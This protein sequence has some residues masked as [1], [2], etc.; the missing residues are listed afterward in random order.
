MSKLFIITLPHLGEGI[1]SA[2]VSEVL[3]SPGDEINKDDPII[4]LESE[5]ASMEI[6]TETGGT[7]KEVYVKQGALISTGDKIISITGNKGPQK[8][9]SKKT[10]QEVK[11][12]ITP[13]DIHQKEAYRPAP[14]QQTP[15]DNFRTSPSVRKLARELNINL[16]N[17]QGTGKK[18]RIT[19]DD[20]I[21]KIKKSMSGAPRHTQ[22][23]TDFSQWG[24]VEYSPLS[25]IKKIT[26]QR[27]ESAWRSIPQVTQFDKADIT[28]LDEHRQKINE[29]IETNKTTFLPFLIKASV[30]TLKEFPNFNSSLSAEK[31]SLIHKNYYH[32]SIAVNTPG[33]LVV[34]VVRDADKK[35]IKSLSEELSDISKRARQK[36]LKPEEFKGGTFTLSS[37]GGIGG[38]YF[39]PIINPPQVAILGVSRA[40]WESVFLRFD[41][42]FN[43][44]Y[45]L[46]L[47]LTYDHRVID[48]VEAATFTQHLGKILSNLSC[49]N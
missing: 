35:D 47:S 21:N 26:G 44:R 45:M 6:P 48:G 36:K 46:P 18:G 1:D 34:P 12:P 24:P 31:D 25:R 13:K 32:I 10:K 41:K 28:E 49:F 3:V 40:Q 33:G 30:Q 4:V 15:K 7:V 14:A 2:D 19:R 42:D 8:E 17:I 11:T 22:E 37:L 20:L 29:N 9:P 27:T 39:S 38:T 23:K 43:L 16:S 5:K